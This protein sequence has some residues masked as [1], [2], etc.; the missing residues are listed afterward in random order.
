MKRYDRLFDRI[1]S[2]E[3]L[4]EANRR[5]RKGKRLTP[6]V[7]AFESDVEASLLDLKQE[8][9]DRTYRP[10]AYRTFTVYERKPRLISA[11]P[12]RDRVVH[13]A[14]HGLIEPIFDSTFIYDSYACRVGK[15]THKAV[16][17]F[18]EFCRKSRYVLKTDISQY[19]AYI[20]HGLLMGK[21]MRKIKCQDTLWLL[22]LTISGSN[23]QKDAFQYFAGD[24]LFTPYERRKGIPIGNL[25]S[26]I[27]ANIYLNDF[28]HYVKE[29]LGC[30]HYIRYV[31]DIAVFGKEKKQLWEIKDRLQ[32]FLAGDR[33]QL[34]P[35]KTYVLPV[36]AGVDHLGYRIYPTHRLLRKDTSMRF[37]RR[38]KKLFILFHQR[39]IA[40]SELNAHVQSWLGH[41]KHADT[42]GLRSNLLW[43]DEA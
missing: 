20:D 36:S 21:I 7:L 41:A 16:Q 13:H 1:I 25:T 37:R 34:H 43:Y 3:N 9:E 2:F 19:F 28:D 27:F 35:R 26:Q 12:Y 33:L 17:R 42:F 30:R 31:D 29:K 38:L 10:G 18:S 8:L 15:G 5:A 14:V 11:A 39:R 4:Y 22:N 32:E 6:N 24:D 23:R 40:F